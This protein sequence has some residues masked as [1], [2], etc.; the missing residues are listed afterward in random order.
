M[1]F[2][3]LKE[4]LPWSDQKAS[5]TAV[6]LVSA[7]CPLKWSLLLYSGGGC[8]NEEKSKKNSELK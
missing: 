5:S 2:L 1:L 7:L 3:Y 6:T 8:T 4:S